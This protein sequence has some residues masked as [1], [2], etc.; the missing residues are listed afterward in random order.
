MESGIVEHWN[1]LTGRFSVRCEDGTYAV[2]KLMGPQDPKRGDKMTWDERGPRVADG[3]RTVLRNETKAVAG[4]HVNQ[5]QF[6]LTKETAAALVA[7][8]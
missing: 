5:G 4:V 8:R 7:M 6:G 3:Y 1:N 2:F